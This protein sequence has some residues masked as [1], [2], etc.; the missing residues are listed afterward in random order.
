MEW[1]KIAPQIHKNSIKRTKNSNVSNIAINF[2]NDL[3]QFFKKH[4]TNNI[5]IF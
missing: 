1:R 5:E 4:K 3:Q 2:R